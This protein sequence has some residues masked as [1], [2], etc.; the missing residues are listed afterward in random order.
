MV[1]QRSTSET[2]H[3]PLCETLRKV[4]EFAL[5]KHASNKDWMAIG[6]IYY[7]FDT[8]VTTAINSDMIGSAFLAGR[9]C[10]CLA[11]TSYSK[12]LQWFLLL[13]Q[14]LPIWVAAVLIGQYGPDFVW[15]NGRKI[16][17]SS[18]GRP[19]SRQRKPPRQSQSQ[20]AGDGGV[21]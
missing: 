5:W 4:P 8:T 19:R 11:E 13:A 15:G 6:W 14:L 20:Q 3:R 18:R 21:P 9:T 1:K 16:L 10:L 17:R 7:H 2:Y 12:R